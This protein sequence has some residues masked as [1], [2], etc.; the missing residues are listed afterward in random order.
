MVASTN[1]SNSPPETVYSMIGSS[2]VGPI[3]WDDATWILTSSFIIFTMQSGWLCTYC[4]VVNKGIINPLF[5]VNN[6]YQ[7][8]FKW[9]SLN[10]A[11][12]D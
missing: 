3:T 8:V 6:L 11:K 5:I 12:H 4:T 10:F 9:S 2:S 7:V 1:N